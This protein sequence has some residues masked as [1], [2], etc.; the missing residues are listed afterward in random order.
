MSLSKTPTAPVLKRRFGRLVAV[1]SIGNVDGHATMWKC[2]CDCGEV[3]YTQRTALV[4]GRTR[5][6]G[7]LRSSKLR[8]RMAEEAKAKGIC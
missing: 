1:Q 2:R 7:C 6:C 8:A 4:Q 3:T 5:S